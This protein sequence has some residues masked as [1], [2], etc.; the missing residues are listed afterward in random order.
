[1]TQVP[2]IILTLLLFLLP[3]CATTPLPKTLGVD[4]SPRLGIIGFKVTAPISRLASIMEN[5][6]QDVDPEEEKALLS[7]V[8]NDI[9]DLASDHLAKDLAEEKEIEPVLIPEGILGTQRGEKP[10]PLQI[11]E[12]SKQFNLDAVLYGQIPSYGK[13]RLIYPIIAETLDIAIET[14]IIGVVTNWNGPIIF[15]N[16]GL[17]LLLNTPIWFGGA[18]IFGWAF[19]PVTVE[20]WVLSAADGK[21][22]W[23]ESFDRIISGKVLKTYPESEQSKKEVQLEASLRRAIS[24]LAK[25]LSR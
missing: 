11:E 15:A 25:S 3:A 7:N 5:P 13:T 10:S 21:G 4:H 18:Y 23:H 12:L 17:E 24:S 22:I 14:V 19:R 16:I 1:M 6:P 2:L 9:G 8:L 20:A